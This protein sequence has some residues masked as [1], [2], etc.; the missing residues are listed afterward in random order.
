LFVVFDSDHVWGLGSTETEAFNDAEQYVTDAYGDFD[1]RRSSGQLIVAE[2]GNKIV[3]LVNAKGGTNIKLYK[4]QSGK[5]HL[6][7]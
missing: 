5:A 3:A 1:I 2:A 4:D 7:N 6:I